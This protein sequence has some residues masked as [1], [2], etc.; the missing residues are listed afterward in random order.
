M[1]NESE[2]RTQSDKDY[3]QFVDKNKKW[4]K[5]RRLIILNAWLFL[6]YALHFLFATPLFI[7]VVQAHHLNRKRLRWQY[8]ECVV[9]IHSLA[10]F[11]FYRID[12]LQSLPQW[13]SAFNYPSGGKVSH[14]IV[15]C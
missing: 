12:G 2:G 10:F 11:S 15:S 1:A 8:D 4:Y 3:Y 14:I 13:N 5:N 6:L 7:C 9:Q